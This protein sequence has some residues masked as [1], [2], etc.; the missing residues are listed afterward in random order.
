MIIDDL[1]VVLG[2]VTTLENVD[3][4]RMPD[5]GANAAKKLSNLEDLLQSNKDSITSIHQLFKDAL[6]VTQ[7]R[8]VEK[9]RVSF[10]DPMT[11]SQTIPGS[12]RP[13]AVFSYDNNTSHSS[14]FMR[15]SPSLATVVAAIPKMLSARKAFL[16]HRVTVDDKA[17]EQRD[18]RAEK[19]LERRA[20][21][22]RNE[23]WYKD[24][25]KAHAPQA[26]TEK[27]LLRVRVAKGVKHKQIMAAAKA[28]AAA[29]GAGPETMTKALEMLDNCVPIELGQQHA[30]EQHK[31]DADMAYDPDAV[32]D[33]ADLARFVD[34]T[35]DIGGAREEV[36]ITPGS[37]CWL[38]AMPSAALPVI[39]R[40]VLAEM[41]VGNVGHN[42]V[43]AALAMS[44]HKIALSDVSNYQG[45]TARPYLVNHLWTSPS[46]AFNTLE[47]N[48]ATPT[49]WSMLNSCGKIGNQLNV[50]IPSPLCPLEGLVLEVDRGTALVEVSMPIELAEQWFPKKN[51][52]LTYCKSWPLPKSNDAAKVIGLAKHHIMTQTGWPLTAPAH[53]NWLLVAGPQLL[54]S[55]RTLTALGT[56]ASEKFTGSDAVRHI[57]C[58]MEG[59]PLLDPYAPVRALK[60]VLG[61]D[62]S[63]KYI[64]GRGCR[65]VLLQL[66]RNPQGNALLTAIGAPTA[67]DHVAKE[68]SMVNKQPSP[69][70]DPEA[71]WKR[72]RGLV[73]NPRVMQC[74]APR[75][76]ADE[77]VCF[78]KLSTLLDPDARLE[79]TIPEVQIDRIL[80]TRL[81]E[82]EFKKDSFMSSD[83]VSHADD[84]EEAVAV[85][86]AGR[87]YFRRI[88]PIYNTKPLATYM[89]HSKSPCSFNTR[90]TNALLTKH[91]RVSSFTYQAEIDK[92]VRD[93]KAAM[94]A[95]AS[96]ASTT[97]DANAF[98]METERSM[99]PQ[100]NHNPLS[101][102]ELTLAKRILDQVRFFLLIAAY[103]S[104]YPNLHSPQDIRVTSLVFLTHIP[105]FS[106]YLHSC[107]N[108]TPPSAGRSCWL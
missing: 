9:L 74:I 42:I 82:L 59:L 104:S 50:P 106:V 15:Y 54:M 52:K 83:N 4:D 107:L 89:W 26:D 71:Q 86:T 5:F 38:S 81:R 76:L 80:C 39:P 1:S 77:V 99:H 87:F 90:T 108:S 66:Q 10:L 21:V 41:G 27:V 3:I 17:M 65:D 23:P 29:E 6:P 70:D 16:A 37:V 32:L 18:Q 56:F 105:I 96:A 95:D 57:I 28:L 94:T 31:E 55:Q 40:R 47:D 85:T 20:A 44:G 61:L 8:A 97:I 24:Y 49:D 25:V 43:Q 34:L 63:G 62:D 69:V 92:L 84:V 91:I 79:R 93:Y 46:K 33:A 53:V 35:D 45:L 88:L 100:A 7:L 60:R 102:G 64:P 78:A 13:I 68:P 72:L 48:A 67:E 2:L 14:A 12:N 22:F 51:A 98:P 101:H 11:R 73:L 58:R 103:I 36:D 19:T 75:L 30:L